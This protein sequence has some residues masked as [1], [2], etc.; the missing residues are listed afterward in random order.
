MVQQIGERGLWA[1]DAG[2]VAAVPS[3]EA[4]VRTARSARSDVDFDRDLARKGE[5]AAGIR[6]LDPRRVRSKRVL[7]AFAHRIGARRA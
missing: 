1:T 2:R 3:C 7:C 5:L 6:E 4:G